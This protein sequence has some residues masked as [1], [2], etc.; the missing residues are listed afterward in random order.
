MVVRASP[1]PSS[2]SAREGVLQ[3]CVAAVWLIVDAQG[4]IL[5]S[6][7]FG[8]CRDPG[9]NR[10]PSD[11]QSDALPTELSRLCLCWGC[12]CHRR[13]GLAFRAVACTPWLLST[14]WVFCIARV[15]FKLH[16]AG[17][18]LLHLGVLAGVTHPRCHP[19]FL[20]A[21]AGS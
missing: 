7:I 18:M 2:F 16:C 15:A 14:S 6:R 13:L 4:G 10:G 21:N 12:A 1:S 17:G 19:S 8:K 20:S 3:M 11:L 5:K 9:S